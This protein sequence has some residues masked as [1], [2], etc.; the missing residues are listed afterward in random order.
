MRQFGKIYLSASRRS[1]DLHPTLG[2]IGAGRMQD[3]ALPHCLS[4]FVDYQL[5]LFLL[6]VCKFID[7]GNSNELMASCAVNTTALFKLHFVNECAKDYSKSAIFVTM[8]THLLSCNSVILQRMIFS[9][10]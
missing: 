5:K 1:N 8:V 7:S 10:I 3:S 6:C 9:A 4:L 2:R